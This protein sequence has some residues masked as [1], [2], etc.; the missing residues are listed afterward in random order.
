V[1]LTDDLLC[2]IPLRFG[3]Q[4]LKR[5]LNL[6]RLIAET[7]GSSIDSLAHPARIHECAPYPVPGP[8][9]D[10]GGDLTPRLTSKQ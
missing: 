6:E 10:F 5:E 3:Q 7:R 9:A 4:R 8:A 1:A 2:P